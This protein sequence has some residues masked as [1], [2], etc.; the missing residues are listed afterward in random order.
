MQLAFQSTKL[1]FEVKSSPV[2]SSDYRLPGWPNIYGEMPA[3]KLPVSKSCINIIKRCVY[4][5]GTGIELQLPEVPATV[6]QLVK[7]SYRYR[8]HCTVSYSTGDHF[9]LVVVTG[10]RSKQHLRKFC[11]T[12]SIPSAMHYLMEFMGDLAKRHM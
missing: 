11:F 12:G 4:C 7:G 2:Q 8:Y 9:Q 3:I 1:I 10:Q 5:T 6:L